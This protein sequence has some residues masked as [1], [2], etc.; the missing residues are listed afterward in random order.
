MRIFLF[1]A[2]AFFHFAGFAQ[3]GFEKIDQKCAPRVFNRIDKE[4]AD[5]A[6]DLVMFEQLAESAELIPYNLRGLADNPHDGSAALNRIAI[7]EAD[8]LRDAIEEKLGSNPS[9]SRLVAELSGYQEHLYRLENQDRSAKFAECRTAASPKTRETCWSN[10]FTARLYVITM[11]EFL[12]ETLKE[13]RGAGKES[14]NQNVASF[15]RGRQDKYF[16]ENK[17]L[18]KQFGIRE[19]ADSPYQ[20]RTER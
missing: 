15:F 20:A 10:Y 2:M 7:H 17:T 9:R 6:R 14:G 3:S 1:T 18:Q 19:I 4:T 11:R 5:S 16:A 13:L 8:C 12:V